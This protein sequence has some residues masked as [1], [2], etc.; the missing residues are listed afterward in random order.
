MNY[1]TT[2]HIEL[3]EKSNS[4]DH[5]LSRILRQENFMQTNMQKFETLTK[6]EV[7][8]LELLAN[9]QNN[10]QIAEQLF[11]SRFTVEQHRKN[12]NRKLEIKTYVQLFQ[13]ALAFDLV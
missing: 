1:S 13:Y 11:I 8:I 3:F 6:R 4:F 9:D 12:I 5:K 10:P 7:E 2:Q